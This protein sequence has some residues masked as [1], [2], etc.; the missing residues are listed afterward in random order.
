MKPPGGHA[1]YL[2]ARSFLPDIPV[3]QYPGQA[4]AVELYIQ[5]TGFQTLEMS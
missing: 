4:L 1:I 2:D 5:G 3:Q